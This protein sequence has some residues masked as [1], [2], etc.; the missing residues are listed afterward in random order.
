MVCLI[1]SEKTTKNIINIL[2]VCEIKRSGLMRIVPTCICIR[3][4]KNL[5]I[6]NPMIEIIPEIALIS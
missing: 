1:L 4:W 6:N 2:D 5:H 3:I